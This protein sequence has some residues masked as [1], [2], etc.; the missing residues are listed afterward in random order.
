[1]G[2][3]SIERTLVIVKPDGVQR[4]LVGAVIS[5]LEG[6]GLRLVAMKFMQISR[7]LASRHYA[8][9]QGK[10]FY[11][12]LLD[13]ITSGPVVVMVWEAHDAIAIVRNT[14]GSTRPAEAAPGTIRGDLGLEVGRNI[15]HGSDGPETAVFEIDLFFDAD[16]LVSWQRS[17]D[18]WIFE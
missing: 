15:V 12:P 7:E 13:Y 4:G 17:V 14:M 2:T 6:R 1:M 10:P 16:E 18:R 8:V 5:R 9:H 11:E 3:E